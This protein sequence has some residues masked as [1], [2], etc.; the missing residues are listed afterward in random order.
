MWSTQRE[1]GYQH[2]GV[3]PSQGLGVLLE[4]HPSRRAV[5]GASSHQFV[6][7]RRLKRPQELLSAR[8]E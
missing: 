4:G 7:T 3:I 5:E 6:P 1:P 8:E 2:C